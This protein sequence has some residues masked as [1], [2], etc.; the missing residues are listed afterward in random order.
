MKKIFLVLLTIIGVNLQAQV[1][2]GINTKKSEL[3]WVGNKIIGSH[4]GK[5]SLSAGKLYIKNNILTGGE[6]TIDMNS[7]TCADVTDADGNAKL[8]GHLK[9]DDFFAT[10]SYPSSSIKITKVEK[11]KTKSSK[12]GNYNIQADLTIKGITKGISF[13][14]TLKKVGSKYIAN[15]SFSID[16]TKWDIRYGSS[17]FFDNLGNKAIKN[18]IEFVVLIESL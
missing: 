2:V 17:S 4:N 14:A 18:E 11:I 1:G 9:G 16:R 3:K 13:P 6:F 5:V 8:I 7:I 12:V 15:A 10:N